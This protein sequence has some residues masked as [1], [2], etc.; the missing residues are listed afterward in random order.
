MSWATKTVIQMAGIRLEDADEW[1]VALA[2]DC[3]ERCYYLDR[4]AEE[5]IYRLRGRLR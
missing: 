2:D 3:L 4:A 1:I 5:L